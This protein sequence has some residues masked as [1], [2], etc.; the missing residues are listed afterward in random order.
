MNKIITLLS[1]IIISSSV[2]AKDL[3]T[4]EDKIFFQKVFPKLSRV[5]L[6]K[7]QDNVSAEKNNNKLLVVFAGKSRIGFIRKI[8]TTTGCNSACLP[9]VYSSFYNEK[10][11]YLKLISRPGLT[12]IYH[13]PMTGE[14][15]GRLDFILAMAPKILSE[16]LEPKEMTDAI[17]GETLKNYKDSVVEGAAYTTL[18]IHLYNQET[19]KH[20]SKYLKS[21]P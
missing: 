4:T 17:S 1:L 15:L 19:M 2:V 10:G 21:N 14:D 3:L 5:E 9:I 11:E 13:A 8:N 12:K 18:R 6:L 7:I 16:V 20:I